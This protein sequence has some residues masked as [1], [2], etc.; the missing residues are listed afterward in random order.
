MD[1][2]GC[3]KGRWAALKRRSGR[4]DPSTLRPMW[5][6]GCRAQPL[7]CTDWPRVR[8]ET[9]A[10]SMGKGEEVKGKQRAQAQKGS[11]SIP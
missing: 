6:V 11:K 8:T 7:R 10:K 2:L 3:D 4:I 1:N 9:N 5:D